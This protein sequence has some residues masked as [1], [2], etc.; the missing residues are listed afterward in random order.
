[1]N[2]LGVFK[3]KTLDTPKFSWT[4]FNKKVSDFIKNL[5]DKAP[6]FIYDH[7]AEASSEPR[8]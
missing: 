4:F 5:D 1:M 8:M 7:A 3:I 2:G 6:F